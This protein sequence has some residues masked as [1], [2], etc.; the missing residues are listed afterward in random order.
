MTEV[1]NPYELYRKEYCENCT[2]NKCPVYGGKMLLSERKAYMRECAE[3]NRIMR[4]LVG[5]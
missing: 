4:L 3:M 5:D 2:D 1:K